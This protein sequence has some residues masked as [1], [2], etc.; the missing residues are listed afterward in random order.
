[1]RPV[2]ARIVLYFARGVVLVAVLEALAHHSVWLV[3]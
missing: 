3:W 1:M 2:E